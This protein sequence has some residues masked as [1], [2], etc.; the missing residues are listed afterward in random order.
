MKRMTRSELIKHTLQWWY[1]D[2]KQ[3]HTKLSADLASWYCYISDGGHSIL[4]I[5]SK[6]IRT[7]RKSDR[8]EYL[9][10]VPVKTVMRGYKVEDEY[11]VVD[12]P[13]DQRMGLI[14]PVEDTEF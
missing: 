7:V 9:V 5:L 3:Y 12:V 14:A 13:Y 8:N 2:G 10:P 1:V 6:D 4:C 11:V